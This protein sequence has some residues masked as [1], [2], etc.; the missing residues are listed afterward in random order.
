LVSTPEG[1]HLREAAEVGVAR[2]R[3]EREHSSRRLEEG[4][5]RA[6]LAWMSVERDVS[7]VHS[8][9]N[10]GGVDLVR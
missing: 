5:L 6:A 2:I 4:R 7:G 9:S 8:R 3:G 10:P 1:C